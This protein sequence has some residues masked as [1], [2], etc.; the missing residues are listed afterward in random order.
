MPEPVVIFQVVFR[1]YMKKFS[2]EFLYKD[3]RN[4]SSVY[5]I[6]SIEMTEG[7]MKH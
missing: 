5:G 4:S 6:S 1:I 7:N 3:E 2:Q